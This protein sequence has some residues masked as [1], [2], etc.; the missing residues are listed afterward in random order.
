MTQF[1][2]YKGAFLGHTVIEYLKI[3]MYKKYT[4]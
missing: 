4:N 3:K 2:F 1:L